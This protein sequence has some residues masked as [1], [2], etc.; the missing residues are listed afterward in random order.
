MLESIELEKIF[1]KKAL[2]LSEQSEYYATLRQ[3]GVLKT[4]EIS[5]IANKLQN[6]RDKM[7]QGRRCPNIILRIIKKNQLTEINTESLFGKKK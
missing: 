5:D 3:S 6:N 2:I 7:F 1:S 4:N